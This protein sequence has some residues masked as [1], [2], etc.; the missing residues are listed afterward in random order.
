MKLNTNRFSLYTE[1]K[2]AGDILCLM[3][4]FNSEVC[5]TGFTKLNKKYILRNSEP[6]T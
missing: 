2:K 4:R 1:K 6:P 5:G 3:A